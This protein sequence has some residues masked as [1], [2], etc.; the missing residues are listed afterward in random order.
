MRAIVTAPCPSVFRSDVDQHVTNALRIRVLQYSYRI[1][2]QRQ[3]C[4]GFIPRGQPP[5][6]LEPGVDEDADRLVELW[7][8]ATND[9]QSHSDSFKRLARRSGTPSFT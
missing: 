3:H 2:A 9:D 4:V 6:K 7:L 5:G 8:S 1:A